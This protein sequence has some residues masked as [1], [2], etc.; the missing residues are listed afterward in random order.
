MTRKS[1]AAFTL[2][3]VLFLAACTGNDTPTPTPTPSISPSQ[4]PTPTE[5]KTSAPSP[6]DTNTSE[7]ILN[8][9]IAPAPDVLKQA[10][11]LPVQAAAVMDSSKE[12]ALKGFD[13]VF[14]SGEWVKNDRE[15]I[16]QTFASSMT[17]QGHQAL[18]EIDPS[19]P[20]DVAALS[21]IAAVF[22]P[23]DNIE[24]SAACQESPSQKSCLSAPITFSAPTIAKDGDRI[25]AT[26]TVTAERALMV[27]D[28]PHASA[29]TLNYNLWLKETEANNWLVD[30]FH[31]SYVYGQV[32]P[33]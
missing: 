16:A 11:I 1:L 12:F 10:G 6:T 17:E 14:L 8:E 21:S 30:A 32:V 5:S 27:D 33:R 25:K 28:K 3:G 7:P 13:P 24:T 29:I 23:V 31:N 2:L 4:T 18:T 9:W 15:V 19:N 20:L 22:Q 26:F